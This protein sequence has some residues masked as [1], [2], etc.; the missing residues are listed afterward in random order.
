MRHTIFIDTNILLRHLTHLIGAL[1]DYMKL[2]I[3]FPDAIYKQ[4]AIENDLKIATF[5]KHFIKIKA[6]IY[7]FK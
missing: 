2:N 5:D 6:P 3:D 7:Q 4:F 1:N